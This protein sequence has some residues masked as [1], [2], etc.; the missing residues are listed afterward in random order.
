M[1]ENRFG[2]KENQRAT[3]FG[4]L[5]GKYLKAAVCKIINISLAPNNYMLYKDAE[6]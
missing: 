3:H 6:G 1:Q 5:K 4:N 2:L